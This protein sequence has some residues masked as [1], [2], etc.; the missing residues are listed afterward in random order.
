MIDKRFAKG[1]GI[2]KKTQWFEFTKKDRGGYLL[3]SGKMVEPP[4]KIFKERHPSLKGLIP[5]G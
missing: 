1:H 4:S 3:S 2:R 5:N